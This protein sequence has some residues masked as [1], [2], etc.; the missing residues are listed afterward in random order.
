MGSWNNCLIFLSLSFV[1]WKKNN[2]F[3]E[4]I[5]KTKKNNGCKA[6]GI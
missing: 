2:T 5:E 1:I 3:C 6:P 4:I